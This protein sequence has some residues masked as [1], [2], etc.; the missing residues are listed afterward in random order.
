MGK[1]NRQKLDMDS[2]DF[3]ESS[4]YD[5][6]EEY[7]NSRSSKKNKK[8]KRRDRR[9]NYNYYGDDDFDEYGD[10]SRAFEGYSGQDDDPH[11]DEDSFEE[12]DGAVDEQNEYEEESSYDDYNSRSRHSFSTSESSRSDVYSKQGSFSADRTET[13]NDRMLAHSSHSSSS[14]STMGSS[15]MFRETAPQQ[16]KINDSG[17]NNP[18]RPSFS[19][20]I[21]GKVP[22][23]PIPKPVFVEERSGERGSK[24]TLAEDLNSSR[25]NDSEDYAEEGNSSKKRDKELEEK[26]RLELERERLK[27]RL[28]SIDMEIL[29]LDESASE[30]IEDRSLVA[31]K[32]KLEKERLALLIKKTQWEIDDCVALR[33]ESGDDETLANDEAQLREEL[34]RLKNERKNLSKGSLLPLTWASNFG[35][36]M[37]SRFGRAVDSLKNWASR[38]SDQGE[39]NQDLEEEETH[40]VD[41]MGNSKRKKKQKKN[42]YDELEGNP[43]DSSDNEEFGD[44]EE[45]SQSLGERNWRGIF[46]RT[47]ITVTAISLLLTI[48]YSGWLIYDGQKKDKNVS[49]TSVVSK[50]NE[51]SS[52]KFDS[53]TVSSQ[54]AVSKSSKLKNDSSKANVAKNE[55]VEKKEG[56]VWNRI[57]SMFSWKRADKNNEQAKKQQTNNKTDKGRLLGQE[58]N[59]SKKTEDP[60]L[61]N[62]N[63]KNE[64]SLVKFAKDTNDSLNGAVNDAAELTNDMTEEIVSDGSALMDSASEAVN[65]VVDDLTEVADNF[66]ETSEELVDQASNSNHE[67]LNGASL[68]DSFEVP[69]ENELIAETDDLYEGVSSSAYPN[70]A[71]QVE[72]PVATFGDV[73]PRTDDTA[74]FQNLSNTNIASTPSE[75]SVS[76]P[77][78]TSSS[79]DSSTPSG[80]D[81]ADSVTSSDLAGD[82][83]IAAVEDS[84]A[85][86][87]N[88][89]DLTDGTG[90]SYATLDE[91]PTLSPIGVEDSGWSGSLDEPLDSSG[92]FQSDSP[93]LELS[94]SSNGGLLA[95]NNSS[96]IGS[97]TLGDD[98]P[99]SSALTL[100]DSLESP[101]LTLDDVSNDV[102]LDS[103]PSINAYS[104]EDINGNDNPNLLAPLATAGA[105]TVD[106][107]LDQGEPLLS[108]TLPESAQSV[109]SGVLDDATSDLADDW[110]GVSN[111][112]T[113]DLDANEGGSRV[114]RNL[115]AMSEQISGT[116]DDLSERSSSLTEQL[117]SSAQNLQ[118][119]VQ[120]GLDSMNEK[121]NNGLET[122]QNWSQQA[123]DGLTETSNNLTNSISGTIDSVDN[124]LRNTYDNVA[125]SL[126]NTYNNT[127]DSLQN[128]GNSLQSSY[129][130]VRNALSNGAP[131][132]LRSNGLDGIADNVN[133]PTN[134]LS[135]SDLN[136]FGGEGTLGTEGNALTLNANDWGSSSPLNT[137][138]TSP[139]TN[140]QGAGTIGGVNTSVLENGDNLVAAPGNNLL[141]ANSSD[142]GKN[143]VNSTVSN[144][145]FGN[146]QTSSASNDL[147]NNYSSV[148]DNRLTNGALADLPTYGNANP[149]GAAVP[150]EAPVN[151][152]YPVYESANV[153]PVQN[154]GA[155]SPNNNQYSQGGYYS[156]ADSRT[157]S[158]SLVGV[159]YANQN[160]N[161]QNGS[162]TPYVNSRAYD[163]NAYNP[164]GYN[165]SID[166]PNSS[167]SNWSA[168][169]NAQNN[170]GYRETNRTVVGAKTSYREYVTKEGDNL[171]TIAE[172][173]LG[174]SSRWSEIKRLNNLRSGATYFE[175]GT[176]IKLPVSAKDD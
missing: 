123:S 61:K 47:A 7:E 44:S 157:S 8:D 25:N 95:E 150:S 134:S 155:Y 143:S 31:K 43:I 32:R 1:K 27:E 5:S 171:L 109:S 128:V 68:V 170:Y 29:E 141:S 114:S 78:T 88:M 161:V 144:P 4:Y 138:G 126:S 2:I 77:T 6:E 121:I 41:D 50:V 45:Y 146:I 36:S 158:N 168:V 52:N 131:N 65:E 156:N 3:E 60:L 9:N 91:N 164:N 22:L 107:S 53:K 169:N 139:L 112:L 106:S 105:P 72:D 137:M 172:N 56:G 14:N 85:S 58:K 28:D 34:K 74:D 64:N 16:K 125:N 24:A 117:N 87:T 49:A 93:N 113:S 98:L 70:S 80:A 13:S 89:E 124:G 10:N 76:V 119:S 39:S 167:S 132:S 62:D 81:W 135:S 84:F 69:T 15:S 20:S 71:P 176:R 33:E 116:L 19:L 94:S 142:V 21:G 102:S 63:L 174:S 118:T 66:A 48:G 12:Q 115:N 103:S 79:A 151:A 145:N 97:L 51:K 160:E 101:S 122:V 130:D 54:K 165:L 166:A 162:V 159:P 163:N 18:V 99:D 140:E 173:E 133:T 111:G 153:L 129:D 83:N 73:Q 92:A 67:N 175:V 38:D 26:E 75:P 46:K 11:V 96:T 152:A 154:G 120:S 23:R 100:D 82:Q 57:K 127:L 108:F 147:P 136:S 90:G 35:N 40:G 104:S 17:S 86:S 37:K 59:L 42:P 30:D 149:S 55:N 110:N 148:G